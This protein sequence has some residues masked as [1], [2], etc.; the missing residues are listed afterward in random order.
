[1][2]QIA[3]S[4][5]KRLALLAD[6][7][8]AHS[9][10]G[11]RRGVERE[12]LR[13][14][15]NGSLS[16]T[17]HPHALG[18]AL[19]HSSITTD[20]SEALLEFITPPEASSQR[21]LQQLAD[22]HKFVLDNIGDERLWPL[23]MPC[24]LQSDEQIPIAQYGS[25]NIGKMKTL[26]RTG[27]NRRYGSMMQ[28][29][30]GV[31]FNFSLPE[32]FWQPWLSVTQ[33]EQSGQAGISAEYFAL[34]RNYHRHC[35]LIPY[36]FGASPALCSSFLQGRDA[37]LA[38]EKL[39]QGSV[40]LPYAT[41]LRMSDLGYT[42]NAQSSIRICHNQLQTYINTVRSAINTPYPEYQVYEPLSDG[43]LQQLNANIL[44]IENELY[45]PI[46]PKQ[47]SLHLEKPTDALQKRG[48]SYIEVRALD[49]NPYSPLGITQQQ[50]DFLDVFLLHC[51]V[52]PS[53]AMDVTDYQRNQTNL[54]RVVNDGRAPGMTLQRAQGE[55]PL[56]DWADALFAEFSQLAEVLDKQ[57]DDH[58]YSQAVTTE[59]AKVT[60]S[61]LTPSAKMLDSMLSKNIGTGE[62]GRQ[63]A[64]EYKASLQQHQYQ[65]YSKQAF[66]EEAEQSMAKQQAREAADTQ[67]FTT[68]L[69]DYFARDLSEG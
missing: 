24:Y 38:F 34:I 56:T 26:Y 46:R 10:T 16:Q 50:F 67:D 11:I 68:F 53:P 55:K 3:D 43:S 17:P 18:S 33:A 20:F 12:A 32:H 1:M 29:I 9:L 59:Y 64:A 5:A 40:Y 7:D 15:A 41:S 54:S 69:A 19:T 51:L 25:S 39:G 48:V 36:L 13:V 49:V 47:P 65:V 14:N 57:F 52:N 30:A 23:S 22:V 4:F 63:L 27:L 45:S 61:S 62:F 42:S 44:Q 31:H 2:T 6:D 58:R 21:S 37:G 8:L 28:A 35:W 60:D 66:V